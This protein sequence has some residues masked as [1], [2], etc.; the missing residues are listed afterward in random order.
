[1]R[2][3][4]AF[5]DATLAPRPRA[6]A[7]AAPPISSDAV[8]DD[9][10]DDDDDAFTEVV[11]APTATD[12]HASAAADASD[13]DVPADTDDDD[14]ETAIARVPVGPLPTATAS[15][16]AA[17]V[18]SQAIAEVVG[19]GA[20]MEEAPEEARAWVPSPSLAALAAR[21]LPEVPVVVPPTRRGARF[22]AVVL[23]AAAAVGVVAAVVG[24]GREDE[25]PP[26]VELDGAWV[27]PLAATEVAARRAQLV[28]QELARAGVAEEL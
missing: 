1:M 2:A 21:P 7:T 22:A 25:A 9:V 28:E 23:A 16:P 19:D 17:E 15:A 13:E 12:D 26:V 14:E 27:A 24:I 8:D 10:D 4:T 3:A 20:A 6:V 11:E 5:G 18:I